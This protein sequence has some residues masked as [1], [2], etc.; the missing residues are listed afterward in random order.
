MKYVINSIVKTKAKYLIVLDISLMIIYIIINAKILV[1]ISSAI[2][3][4]SIKY[5]NLVLIACLV[6]IAISTI[7]GFT[8]FYRH[9]SFTYLNEIF[10]DK[11]LDSDIALFNKFS[12]G[13]VQNAE[14]KAWHLSTVV[15][16]VINISS[17]ILSVIVNIVAIWLIQPKVIIPI[18]IIFAVCAVLIVIM[19]NKWNDIDKESEQLKEKRNEE[20]DEIINGFTEVRSFSGT[21]EFHR[22][23]IKTLNKAIKNYTLARQ[24]ING[25]MDFVISLVDTLAMMFVLT[26]I[27]TMSLA[28]NVNIPS[29]TSITLIMYIWR[30]ID[31]L[32]GVVF[33]FSEVSEY[34]ASIPKFSQIMEYQNEI[35]D[36]N[37]ELESFNSGIEIN[38]VSF[39]YDGSDNVLNN[40]TINIPKGS[41]IGICGVSGGGKST[42]L[43]LLTRFYDVDTGSIKIDGIDI[44]NLKYASLRKY[45]GIVHQNTYIFD[46]TIRDN[47]AYALAPSIPSDEVIIEACKKAS[48]E[49][50]VVSLPE[51]LNTKVGPRGLK[52]SGGQK[53]RIGLARIFLMNPE[54]VV[55]D[56]ATSALD[57]ETES[58]V[59]DA[60]C[61]LKDKTIITIAHRLSTIR[62]SDCIYVIDNH[63]VAERGNHQQLIEANGIYANMQK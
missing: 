16:L 23:N 1:W 58:F 5:V 43:R 33:S 47:I 8:G 31:P 57:N 52:L 35:I 34:K 14:G 19:N 30:I 29:A 55:L 44:R 53:Q 56:E 17:N 11:I 54:I 20:M 12:P 22:N 13:A 45:I 63:T 49:G 3:L 38:N 18:I 7:R 50:F 27:V 2:H 24:K 60:L 59:Q 32:L 62:D 42:L 46:G 41:K 6:Q 40:V 37:I 61:S 9:I 21:I 26:Y 28:G 51:G 4:L 25:G 10:V 15:S 36:G 48:I 39:S